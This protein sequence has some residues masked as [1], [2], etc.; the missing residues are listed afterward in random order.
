MWNQAQD[1]KNIA[2][3]LAFDHPLNAEGISQ[4]QTF[5]RTW[6]Q[7]RESPSSLSEDE[8]RFFDVERVMASPLT[9]AVQTA[10]VGL[11]GHPTMHQSGVRLHAQMREIKSTAGSFDTTG[12]VVGADHIQHRALNKLQE[13]GLEPAT[14][15]AL[16]GVAFDVNDA[17]HSW[18]TRQLESDTGERLDVRLRRFMDTLRYM[19][20]ASVICAGHSLFFRELMKRFLVPEFEQAHPEFYSILKGNG[21]GKGKMKNAGCLCVK[22]RFTNDREI[23][24]AGNT[25]N[26][27]AQI[28]D[29]SECFAPAMVMTSDDKRGSGMYGSVA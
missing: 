22:V 12:A 2:G 3:M 5:N 13:Q 11:Q 8:Q 28:I 24:K 16:S 17:G 14:V 25:V 9:R 6:T 27:G 23:H 21:G 10:L 29:V 18:W 7:Q 4:C 20:E 19:P 26:S 1:A 15:D